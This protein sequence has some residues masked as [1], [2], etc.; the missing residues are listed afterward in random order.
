MAKIELQ[1]DKN[2]K[3]AII[4]FESKSDLYDVYNELNYME[5]DGRRLRFEQPTKPDDKN[6]VAQSCLKFW[7]YVW[8]GGRKGTIRYKTAE[9]A[10]KAL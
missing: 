10:H 4:T 7:W 9:A 8:K 5:Y 3:K 2:G 6:M 1:D